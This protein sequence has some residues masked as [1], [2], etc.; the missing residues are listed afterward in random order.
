MRRFASFAFL[1]ATLAIKLRL[2][3]H[4]AA[5]RIAAPLFI[6]AMPLFDM[7]RYTRDIEAAYAGMWERWCS[8]EMPESFQVAAGKD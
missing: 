5:T 1:L 4:S 6:L 3:G 8:G 7:T 2:E